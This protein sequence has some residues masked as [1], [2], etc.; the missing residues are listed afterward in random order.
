VAALA[1]AACGGLSGRQAEAAGAGGGGT[2][3]EADTGGTTQI[4][5]TGG[6]SGGSSTGGSIALTRKDASGA[7]ITV[8]GSVRA[9][10][11]AA[12]PVDARDE[13][14]PCEPT[15]DNRDP[16]PITI[17]RSPPPFTRPENV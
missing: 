7:P 5:N 4:A 3:T 10:A 15:W 8:D 16:C 2:D 12:V 9:S 17:Y 1:A 11:D 13:P 14:D 6:S